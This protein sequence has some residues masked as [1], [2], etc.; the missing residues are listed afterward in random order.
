MNVL[1]TDFQGI[2]RALNVLVSDFQGIKRALNMFGVKMTLN[3]FGKQYLKN[4][5]CLECVWWA[6]FRE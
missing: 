2:K 4:K 3:V 5:E 6:T 1:V